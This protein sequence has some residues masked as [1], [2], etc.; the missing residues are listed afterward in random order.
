MFVRIVLL[1]GVGL[2]SSCYEVQS[3]SSPYGFLN[4][5]EAMIGC[6]DPASNCESGTIEFIRIEGGDFRADEDLR[7]QVFVT[8]FLMSRTEV[9]VAQYAACVEA[10]ACVALDYLDE[11]TASNGELP[12]T[13]VTWSEARQFAQFVG[14]RLPTESEWE[15]SARSGGVDQLYPWGSEAAH[16]GRANLDGCVDQIAPVC[17]TRSGSSA[18]GVCDLAGNVSEWV[19]DDFNSDRNHQMPNDGTAFVRQPRLDRRVVRGGHFRSDPYEIRATY[20][21]RERPDRRSELIGFRVVRALE[22]L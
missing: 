10:G 18:Q 14:G 7:Y 20:R 1:V 5:N 12:V 8:T 9:T 2:L 22:N 11:D 16:C 13:Q 6:V 15:Y 17:S 19:E 4:Q 21:G 3:D